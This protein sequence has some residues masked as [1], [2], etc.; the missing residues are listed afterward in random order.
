MFRSAEK[1]IVKSDV[2]IREAL[3]VMEKA[4]MKILLLVDNAGKLLGTCTD[5]DIRRAIVRTGDAN[6][7]ISEAANATPITVSQETNPGDI[8]ALL[9]KHDIHY[10]PVIDDA[11][12]VVSLVSA[13]DRFPTNEMNVP[14]VLMAGGLG[15]R[16]RPLTEDCPKPLLKLGDKPILLR[17]MERFRDQGF[18][19]FYISINYLGHMIEEYFGTGKDFGLEISY[20]REDERLG[21][22]GALA[23][24][25]DNMDEPFI[26]M[27]GDLITEMDFRRLVEHH[28]ECQ[29]IATMCV[30]EHKTTIPFGVVTF[31]GSAYLGVKEKPAL[32]HHINAGI[33]CL[34]KSALSVVPK[35]KEYDMPSLFSD[36]DERGDPCAVHVVH[37][38]WIDIGTQDQFNAAKKRFSSSG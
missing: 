20:L 23:L 3:A 18:R 11:G 2:S 31:E 6:S 19:R 24:L 25:P 30:R 27:N 7:P 33:Y 14:V 21:T 15:R 10:V 12:T 1:N 5:G 26:V 13:E 16:L 34:S 38:A 28:R 29:S 32:T 8:D 4:D 35:G 9:R 36:L 22:G 37:D 17:I